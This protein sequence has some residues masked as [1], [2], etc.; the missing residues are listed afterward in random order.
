MSD[1]L[2]AGYVHFWMALDG[3]TEMATLHAQDFRTAMRERDELRAENSLLSCEKLAI[4]ERALAAEA[5]NER[6]RA[7][8]TEVANISRTSLL[9]DRVVEIVTAALVN[10]KE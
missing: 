4:A 5:E 3:E 8:L 6:L 1:K 7:A 9:P 2:E 10:D